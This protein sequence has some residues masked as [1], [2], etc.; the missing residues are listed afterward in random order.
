MPIN[1]GTARIPMHPAIR[2]AIEAGEGWVETKSLWCID[3]GDLAHREITDPHRVACYK[4]GEV[5]HNPDASFTPLKH[6]EIRPDKPLPKPEEI[7]WNHVSEVRVFGRLN[8][9][10]KLIVDAALTNSTHR[11]S[12]TGDTEGKRSVDSHIT[13]S[14]L[15]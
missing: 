15:E 2:R 4:C 1:S 7:D 3:C 8:P 9:E 10:G 5:T 13:G 6:L 11:V 12:V 14:N